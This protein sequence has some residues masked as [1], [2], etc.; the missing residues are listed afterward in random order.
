MTDEDWE[1]QYRKAIAYIIRGWIQIYMSIYL[2][3]R[4]VDATWKKLENLFEH[5]TSVSN[6]LNSK[7]SQLEV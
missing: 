4:K 7:T 6:Y 2:M 3:K 5:N 1:V